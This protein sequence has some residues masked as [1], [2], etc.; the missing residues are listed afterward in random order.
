[1]K[2]PFT[3]DMRAFQDAFDTRQLAD[4]VVE[5]EFHQTLNAD[6]RH[7]VE[8]AMFFFMASTDAEGHPQCSYK[9]GP[10]G[11][12]RVTGPAELAFPLYQGNGL[13]L[14]AGNLAQTGKIGLLFVDFERQTRLRING[15]ARLECDDPL[16][17]EIAAAQQ[18][19]RV[20]I[21]DIH[22]NC[23]RNVHKMALIEPSRYTPAQDSDDVSNAPW[24]DA[25]SDVLPEH[26][27]PDDPLG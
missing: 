18:I 6:D 20:S 8:D 11:F 4:R 16:L 10:R 22:P 1:M 23:P 25:Y 26:M 9:G 27:L 24:T 15:V 5:R 12:V 14:S 21:R 17:S 3:P 19:V 2:K 13:Y 7:F